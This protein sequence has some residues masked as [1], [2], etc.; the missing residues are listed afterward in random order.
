MTI[1]SMGIDVIRPISPLSIRGRR[2]ILT[3]T[4]YFSKW[5][6][7]IL[8]I[9]VKTLNVI[10]FIKHHAIHRFGVLR[11]IVHDNGPQFARQS[12]F[13]FWEKYRIQNV[14]STAYNLAANRLVEVF[15]KMIIKLLKKFISSSKLDWNEKLSECLWAY[16]ITVRAPISTTLFSLVYGV[17]SNHTPRNP[18]TITSCCSG[19]QDDRKRQQSI[20]SPRVL[21]RWTRN[22][23]KWIVH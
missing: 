5:A 22:N 13:Q 23:Y 19:N 7:A 17:W 9:E 16:R 3:I 15:N 10:N 2:F 18:K 8:L 1:W 11:R 4:D 20:T 6:E 21:K 14:A 12:F